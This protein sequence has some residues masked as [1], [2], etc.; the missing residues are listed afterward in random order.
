MTVL[1]S[2]E[3]KIQPERPRR[4]DF[5][6]IIAELESRGWTIYKIAARINAQYI[7]VQRIKEG[8]RVT[9]PIDFDLL[10]LHAEC[11]TGNITNVPRRRAKSMQ[12][13]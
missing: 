2:V 11:S 13:A 6:K 4:H 7:Q 8:G 5:P 1:L 12:R 3:D 9:Y 10:A